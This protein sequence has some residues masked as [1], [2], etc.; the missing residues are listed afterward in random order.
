[1][2]TPFA[3]SSELLTSQKVQRHPDLGTKR[4]A[5]GILA[6]S[7]PVSLRLFLSY[8]SVDQE[9]SLFLTM[10]SQTSSPVGPAA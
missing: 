6:V 10:D 5:S 8:K 1:M 9:S 2:A 3:R 4:L 7:F